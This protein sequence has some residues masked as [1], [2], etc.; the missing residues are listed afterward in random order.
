MD[1][2]S[3]PSM[4]ETVAAVGPS[5]I[6]TTHGQPIAAEEGRFP[7]G[8]LVGGRYRVLGLLG[9]GGMGEVYRATDLMLGQ[10]VA[11]KFLPEEAAHD[12]QLLER[13]HSEVRVARLVSHRNVCRVYDIGQ[14]DG[15]PFIS[16]EY[17]DGE[18]LASLLLRIGRLPSDKALETAR[19]LCAGLAAAHERGVI[20][21]DLKPQN[22]MIDKRGEVVIMDFGLAA[23]AAQLTGAEA[24]H[25]TP[26]YMSPEQLKG[27]GVTAKSDIYALGLV[28]Y[29]IFT[30]KR[31][32]EA[33]TL[34]QMIDRQEAAQLAGMNSVAT[35]ID[36]LV[37]K[38]VRRCLAPDPADRP[39]SPQAVSAA[40]PGGDP[41]AMALAAGET[42]SPEMVAAAGKTEGMAPRSS[43][44]CLLLIAACL[45]GSMAVRQRT[46]ALMHARLDFPPDVLAQKSRDLAVSFGYPNRPADAAVAIDNRGW[47]IAYL[48]SLPE[49]RKWDDWLAREAPLESVYRESPSRLLAFPYAQVTRDNPP[50]TQ[51]GMTSVTLDGYGRLLDF[52]GVP[53][54]VDQ[55][56]AEPVAP[57]TVFRAAGL[58]IANFHETAPVALPKTAA[59]LIRAWK[60]PHP[61]IP[62]T[63]MTIQIA[64]WKGRITQARLDC[65]RAGSHPAPQRS[66]G[67]PGVMYI[68]LMFL[69]AWG[70]IFVPFLAWRNWK[71]GRTDRRGALRLGI[72][73]FVLAVLVWGG[74]VHP[75]ADRGAF[76]VLLD[77]GADCLASAV[78]IWLIYLALEPEV[79]A[80]WP[81]AMVT[82]NRVLAGRWLDAQV[83]AHILI[84]AAIG[85]VTWIAFKL[86]WAALGPGDTLQPADGIPLAAGTRYWVAGHAGGMVTAMIVG[87]T[88]FMTI[89]GM[90]VLLRKDVFAALAASVIFT[91]TET[92]I[93]NAPNSLVLW[94]L[95][96][97]AYAAL[98][99][100]L[101]RF[102]L[103]ATFASVFFIK[104]IDH[105]TL[106][107]DWTAWYAPAGVAT[108]ALLL[109]IAAFA[110][111]RS[112]GSRQLLGGRAPDLKAGDLAYAIPGRPGSR[113]L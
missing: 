112:L 86:I 41:L 59:D 48:Q 43:L 64:S 78:I 99:F 13:F 56:P 65:N 32:F 80:R 69:I 103:V 7:A 36:P 84:G 42:P 23:I 1:G 39:A 66:G 38:V 97:V 11:L 104:G 10:P 49:P 8:T 22:I 94:G 101:L 28:L 15:V 93:Q 107:A 88:A 105:M 21:R 67:G 4:V 82:W 53:Y 29:E 81:H 44:A 68:L 61:A 45:F 24:R 75:A 16:M 58:D 34:Q 5:G 79:R 3:E 25:G 40:L 92:D 85:S 106:G 47:F 6:N 57:E 2:K 110:F 33:K 87:L 77:I 27:A 31:P 12:P 9:R 50:A 89:F 95:Y 60:G 19:K 35:D 37:E 46:S 98:A 108:L 113:P 102:G 70:A 91:L 51:P 30:G 109:V 52:A 71:L 74:A 96:V 20:H 72:A 90:R 111:W 76:F 55:A 83:G 73:R 100:I 54:S 63:E 17:V 14:A 18:D 26:A 62:N